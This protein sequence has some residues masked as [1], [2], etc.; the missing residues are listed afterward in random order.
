MEDGSRMWIHLEILKILS[1]S[2]SN[3]FTDQ[4]HKYKCQSK[5][6]LF[7][8]DEPSS[9]KIGSDSLETF[10]FHLLRIIKQAQ[11]RYKRE[12]IN[13]SFYSCL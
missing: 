1:Y 6:E 4:N 11:N 3:V 7:R 8:E 10:G 9:H 12:N 13:Y 5:E 2:D